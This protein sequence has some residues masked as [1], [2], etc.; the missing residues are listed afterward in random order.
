VLVCIFLLSAICLAE[1]TEYFD[2]KGSKLYAAKNYT[3]AQI[4]FEKAVSQ[5]PAYIDAWI[6]KGDT[7]RALKEY[8]A[9]IDSYKAALKIDSQKAV[10]WSGITEA[11]TAM[12][13]LT[14]ASIAAAKTT[15]LDNN[16]ANWLREGNLLQT[17]EMYQEAVTKFEGALN[18]DP[19]YKDALYKKGFML[20]ALNNLTDAE[21]QFDEALQVDPNFKQAYVAK[22]IILEADGKYLEAQKAYEK[23]LEIDPAY[24]QALTYKMHVLLML[25]KQEEAMK[26]F[27][28]I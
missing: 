18:V 15:E 6:H 7:Q 9:S 1:E 8:N 17:Q 19:A 27:V 12:K 28:K 13:D 25:K 20:M 16:K 22:G 21:K 26:I 5:D 2:W 14:N 24:A 3:G 11:Y 4:Y 10:A 23:A